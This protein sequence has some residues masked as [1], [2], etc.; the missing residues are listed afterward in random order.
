MN[1]EQFDAREDPNGEKQ[2]HQHTWQGRQL[3][4]SRTNR[5]IAGV[6]GGLGELIGVD[7]NLMRLA[8][9]FLFFFGGAGLWI[10]LIMAIV[11]RSNQRTIRFPRCHLRI[12]GRVPAVMVHSPSAS[13]SS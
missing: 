11:I 5:M 3:Y 12:T 13:L 9:I 8:W 6:C 4:R 1:K 10:Y 7:A 2:P